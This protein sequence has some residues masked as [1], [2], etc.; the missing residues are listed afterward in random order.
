M[1]NFQREGAVSNSHVGRDFEK[2]SKDYFEATG[3]RL[4]ENIELPVGLNGKKK[5]HAFDLG[6]LEEKVIVECKAHRWTTGDN[7]PSAKM[8]VWNEAMYYFLVSPADYRK[9]FMVL[10]DYSNKRN[11][12]LAEYYLRTYSHLIPDGVEIW[13]FDMT[14]ARATKLY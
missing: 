8:T 6:S 14:T 4:D 5:K 10:K 13:E 11:E 2:A 1:N 3:L 9:I 12:T 7:V